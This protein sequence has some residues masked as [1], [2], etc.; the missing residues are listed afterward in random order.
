MYN[1]VKSVI[2]GRNYKLADIQQKV[3]KLYVMGD[4]TADQMDELFQM[5]AEGVSADAERPETLDMIKSL[6]ERVTVLE[7]ALESLQNGSEDEE[8]AVTTDYPAWKPWD[9]INTDYQQYSVVLH[10]G[11]LWQSLLNGQN[12]WEPGTAGTDAL[13]VE[14]EALS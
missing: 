10:N 11:K 5:A 13:W 14:Y 3:K 9:G 8:D 2:N 6:S 1:I 7:K 12:V 4:I